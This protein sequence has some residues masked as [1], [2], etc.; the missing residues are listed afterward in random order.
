MKSIKVKKY[1]SNEFT[2]TL[3]D[4]EDYEFLHR[5]NWFEHKQGYVYANG[6][7]K[8][9]HKS[10]IMLHR[11]VVF[12][13]K[14]EVV[15]HIDGDV[16]NN[17]K[18]NLRICTQTENSKNR[19]IGTNNSSGFKGVIKKGNKYHAKIGLNKNRIH[20]G[21]FDTKEEAAKAYNEAAKKYHGD[22]AKLNGV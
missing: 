21:S 2:E 8:E 11:L 22:F 15:D 19:K 1:N 18:S 3:L 9:E 17:Q 12:A 10:N 14:G 7:I 20:L 4:D 13:K 16:K 5:F 6:K